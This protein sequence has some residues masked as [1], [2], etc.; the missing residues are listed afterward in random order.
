M[1]R[2]LRVSLDEAE[3]GSKGEVKKPLLIESSVPVA[4]Y[5]AALDHYMDHRIPIEWRRNLDRTVNLVVRYRGG[6]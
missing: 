6:Q 3:V 5:Y 4:G 2:T 1:R